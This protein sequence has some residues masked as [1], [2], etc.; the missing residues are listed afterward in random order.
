MGHIAKPAFVT[1]SEK[2]IFVPFIHAFGGVER[3]VLGLSRFLHQ[4]DCAH[5]I[6]CFNQTIDLAAHA[7][8]PL[9][10]RELKPRRNPLIEARALSRHLREVSASRADP[11][12]VFDLNGSL[13]AGFSSRGSYVLHLTDPPSLLPTDVSKNALSLRRCGSSAA[14]PVGWCQS[15]RAELVHR[16][17]ARGVR[18]AAAVIVMTHFIAQEIKDL[19]GVTPQIV[20]PGVPVPTQKPARSRVA[21]DEPVRLLSVSRLEANKRIDWILRALAEAPIRTD[22]LVLDV[23]GDGS[24][25]PELKRLAQELGLGQKVV[26][27]GR[28]PD[29]RLKD[30]YKASHVFLMPAVQGYGLP[31]LEALASGTP[32]I[33]HRESGVAE[34][35]TGT[36]WAEVMDNAPG[37]L[38]RA[39]S[40]M[41]GRLRDGFFQ[42]IALPAVPTENDW[43]Q[44]IC[45]TCG[46]IKTH[47]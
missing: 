6:V 9:K 36:P 26:F 16:A 21:H 18:K 17:N 25:A 31:A 19:Y 15:L 4:R 7:D 22:N 35:L 12:L 29:E 44:E 2:T 47:E 20:R 42:T 13:Y 27:H 43:A 45:R 34:I 3:L 40:T 30:I 10:V 39:L 32:V 41:L 28:V 24:Q 14:H 5:V 33:L 46:W 1:P 11:A 38:A 8:W 23:V 37:S